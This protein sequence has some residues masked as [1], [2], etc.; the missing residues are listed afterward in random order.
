MYD[1]VQESNTTNI[2]KIR[3]D[4]E[5][6][7]NMVYKLIFEIHNHKVLNKVF[8]V[9]ELNK[10]FNLNSYLDQ[11]E[12]KTEIKEFEKVDEKINENLIKE[13]DKVKGLFERFVEK[14]VISPDL[15]NKLDDV[16]VLLNKVEW[17]EPATIIRLIKKILVTIQE[18]NQNEE[19]NTVIKV[20]EEIAFVLNIVESIIRNTKEKYID[21]DKSI[22][23]IVNRLTAIINDDE[24][25]LIVSFNYV[26][27]DFIKEQEYLNS[28][29]SAY[30]QLIKEL[31]EF[32]KRINI[33]V[34]KE[35]SFDDDDEEDNQKVLNILERLR[36]VLHLT[37]KADLAKLVES[38]LVV[39]N[40]LIQED[41][42]AVNKE[43]LDKSTQNIAAIYLYVKEYT[44]K[45]LSEALNI[46]YDIINKNESLLEEA[47][48]IVVID[49]KE[50]VEEVVEKEE[51]ILTPVME[52]VIN[53]YEDVSNSEELCD[54]FLMEVEEIFTN[55]KEDLIQIKNNK[56]NIDLFKSIRRYHHTLKG[57]ARMIG[58]ANFA[59]GP[60]IIE[61]TL[62]VMLDTGE[63]PDDELINVLEKTT[64]ILSGEINEFITNGKTVL[65]S[66]PELIKNLILP[67]NPKARFSFDLNKEIENTTTVKKSVD[68]IFKDEVTNILD[69]IK[70]K[71]LKSNFF[72]LD[73][74]GVV[75][76]KHLLQLS[77]VSKYEKVE[78]IINGLLSI[79]FKGNVD[80]I[81]NN[82]PINKSL[83]MINDI[84][85]NKKIKEVDFKNLI[86][87]LNKNIVDEN[88]IEDVVIPKEKVEPIEVKEVEKPVIEEKEVIEVKNNEVNKENE[89]IMNKNILMLMDMVGN[90]T[91]RVDD[92][93]EQNQKLL[94]IINNKNN[95]ENNFELS[96]VMVKLE[97]LE[98]S[99]NMMKE[100]NES[101]TKLL[102]R[103][104]DLSGYIKN[105]KLENDNKELFNKMDKDFSHLKEDLKN[106]VHEE[107]ENSQ[108]E[109]KNYVK[110]IV[111][112][113][114]N[115]IK[116][117][118]AKKKGV[119]F[120]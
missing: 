48:E 7:K 117:D 31:D 15:M 25:T 114:L 44:N 17:K 22:L 100:D 2:K 14:N 110:K 85:N 72:I 93:N 115:A 37:G 83:E 3:S 33:I 59:E 106:Y 88:V 18:K 24:N 71:S 119:F 20:K 69:K 91:K 67:L 70:D 111:L 95:E 107:I 10:I 43:E 30:T 120:N 34:N 80:F 78:K 77:V 39:F 113:S 52:P 63:Y 61:Q 62:N 35:I 21:N 54:I 118:L 49:I 101:E 58:F 26:F 51:D 94:L 55:L 6:Q 38:S 82:Y 76:L 19:E 84:K 16:F 46:Y 5:F 65:I 41:I 73:D 40:K 99:L 9:V 29:S 97:E 112:N 79:N 64:D 23:S 27:P 89:D 109:M 36:G 87:L 56:Q 57:S 4:K 45:N 75:I 8:D 50:Y 28:K 53:K 90:L 96:S 68:E 11:L 102:D 66:Q 105:I 60:W 1:L 98:A 116:A 47:K 81:R 42:S 74:D 104:D 32:D 103:V 108:N 12:S 92:L 86:S 13:F